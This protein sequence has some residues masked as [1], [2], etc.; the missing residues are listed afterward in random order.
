VGVD[1][2]SLYVDCENFRE[3]L[4]WLNYIV[5]VSDHMNNSSRQRSSL[6]TSLSQHGDVIPDMDSTCPNCRVSYVG[7]EPSKQTETSEFQESLSLKWNNG[8]MYNVFLKINPA[9]FKSDDI[10]KELDEFKKSDLSI[11]SG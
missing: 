1:Q 3:T 4:C 2:T 9:L 8:K 6:P 10:R 11:V 7:A 5:L